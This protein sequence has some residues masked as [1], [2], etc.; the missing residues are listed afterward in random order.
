MGWKA[1]DEPSHLQNALTM[2]RPLKDIPFVFRFHVLPS[3]VTD[4]CRFARTSDLGTSLRRKLMCHRLPM[5]PRNW[6]A[7]VACRGSTSPA[8]VAPSSGG[9]GAPGPI[10]FS[11]RNVQEANK[12]VNP[13]A[14]VVVFRWCK[15]VQICFFGGGLQS[16]FW[17][18]KSILWARRI[19][20]R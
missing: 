13:D 9:V 1:M 8:T 6:R 2:F 20:G 19:T 11:K 3:H 12:K 4:H 18:Q 14:I 16:S 5:R 10:L 17:K 7:C 15:H